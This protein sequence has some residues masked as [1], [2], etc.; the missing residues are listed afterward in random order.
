MP[1]HHCR[2]MWQD[3]AGV[4]QFISATP[5]RAHYLMLS[6]SGK[7]IWQGIAILSVSTHHAQHP[8]A[9]STAHKRCPMRPS[10]DICCCT[11]RRELHHGT[12]PSKQLPEDLTQQRPPRPLKA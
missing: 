11:P 4:Q 1:L 2:F 12:H 5:E 6:Y 9:A 3:A 10:K 8:V 7:L